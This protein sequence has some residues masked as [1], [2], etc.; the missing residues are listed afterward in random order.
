[1]TLPAV[2]PTSHEAKA[3]WHLAHMLMHSS[4]FQALCG[5]SGEEDP[6]AGAARYLWIDGD[7]ADG[8]GK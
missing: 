4:S 3:L 6:P 1:M 5:V 7:E 8:T 2:I